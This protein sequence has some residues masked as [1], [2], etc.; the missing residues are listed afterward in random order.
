MNLLDPSISGQI[1]SYHKKLLQNVLPDEVIEYTKQVIT[2]YV[3]CLIAGSTSDAAVKARKAM[4]KVQAVGNSTIVS[5]KKTQAEFAAFVN[6]CAGHALEMDDTIYEAGGHVAVSVIPTALAVAEEL[7]SSGKEMI[8]AVVLGYDTMTRVGHGEIPDNCFERGWHP[9]SV[10]GIFGS[11]VTAGYLMKL[12]TKQMENALGIA[13]GFASGNLECYE[14]GSDTKPLNPANAAMSAILAARLAAADYSGPKWI[15]EGAKGFLR[16][17][18]NDG[19]GIPEK[20]IEDMD[21][22]IFYIMKASFKPYACC[23]YNHC[24]IDSVIQ[25]MNENHLA[26]ED[27]EKVIVDVCSLAV[28]G[29]VEPREVKYN[30]PSIVGAQFSLPY[31]VAIAV[32]FKNA[33]VH[34]Y[35]QELLIDPK[36]HDIMRRTEMIH[37]GEMDQYLPDN[38]AAK[39]IIETKD[40]RKFECL[41]KYNKGDVQNPF[42]KEELKQKYMDLAT[43]AI[44][45]KQ[46]E[47]IYDAIQ[48]LD[49]ISVREMTSVM[50][51]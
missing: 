45:E 47:E 11:V 44:N 5:G 29:V 15:F 1:C 36:I 46:A 41:T 3:G 39:V 25:I 7:D 26:P 8:E 22:S 16:S 28:R 40:H 17:Y 12:S 43:M 13:G 32:L 31:S 23:R 27:I 37:S 14:D 50:T 19:K 18:T 51:M 6:G 30:P 34:E 35:R 38:T 4:E 10:N 42:T 21:K 24:P 48:R 2:D 33:S 20:M 9:T 49:K